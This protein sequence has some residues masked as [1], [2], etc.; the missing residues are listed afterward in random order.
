MDQNSGTEHNAP[1]DPKDTLN[2]IKVKEKSATAPGVIMVTTSFK[3]MASVAIE[4]AAKEK[5]LTNSQYIK[6]VVELALM[7]G[8]HLPDW[9]LERRF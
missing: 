5:H 8:G 9:W 7:K 4:A 6:E 1:P 3:D 2:Y